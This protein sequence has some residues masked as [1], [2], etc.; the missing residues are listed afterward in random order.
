MKTRYKVAVAA[1][2]VL[3]ALAWYGWG[4]SN[5]PAGQLP[6]VSLRKGDVTSLRE[7]FNGAADDVRVVLLL[8]PT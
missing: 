5:T 6:L 3:V 4:P 2:L 1:L 8:S 7:S